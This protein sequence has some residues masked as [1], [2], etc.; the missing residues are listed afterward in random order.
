MIA[1]IDGDI[2]CY[3]VGF[4]I[5]KSKYNI[6]IKGEEHFGPVA[7]YP[8]KKDIPE[9]YAKDEGCY[10]EKVKNVEPLENALHSMKESLQSIVESVGATSYKIYLTGE[11]NFR[12]KISV[13]RKYK[14][15]RDPNHK[16]THYKE[17]KEYLI[18]YWE[19]EIVD[20]MEADD[21]LGIEQYWD[22]VTFEVTPEEASTIICSIDKDLNQIPGWHY[23]I[24]K[25]EKY[26][27]AEDKA[28]RNFYT[29]LLTGDTTDNIQGMEGIGPKKAK[30]IL[31]GC[32][33]EE[34]M[35]NA[36]VKVYDNQV[37]L[38]EMA[39]L[40]YIR[41]IEGEGWSPPTYVSH[42]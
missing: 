42:I 40:V 16:P 22:F 35:Y 1:L 31:D 7:V 36:C 18:K 27:V 25:K 33:T 14:G 17:I 12:D 29:Q 23:N 38:N 34:E 13:T 10:I 37:L 2:L 4:A 21:K 15:N 28:I 24:A 20:G 11:G 26:W 41:R 9:Y 6:Y 8:Y 3:R 32:K 39:Q 5:E 30:K 19:A